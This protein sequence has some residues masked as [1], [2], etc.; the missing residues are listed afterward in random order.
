MNF[1]IYCVKAGTH[2]VEVP[3]VEQPADERVTARCCGSLVEILG[4]SEPEP[5]PERGR[6]V[7]TSPNGNK[8]VCRA[9]GRS[10]FVTYEVSNEGFDTYGEAVAFLKSKGCKIERHYNDGSET[11]RDKD[12]Q[13]YPLS[14]V[15]REV[16]EAEKES[17]VLK[18]YGK[19]IEARNSLRLPDGWDIGKLGS[20]GMTR[21]TIEFEGGSKV[22]YE[23]D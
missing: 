4:Y 7:S 5:E 16:E 6:T 12:G 3:R 18:D 11:W 2:E 23:K 17:W 20:H 8:V 14:A 15:K 21:V 9:A 1:Y 22:V 13:N 19:G 10:D